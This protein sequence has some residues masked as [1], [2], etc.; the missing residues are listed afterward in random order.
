VEL[1]AFRWPQSSADSH[2]EL[3]K[4][5]FMTPNEIPGKSSTTLT[6]SVIICAYT[7]DRWDLMKEAL[8]SVV[9]QE[10]APL[11]V[12]LCI[13]HNEAL[14]KRCNEELAA[15]MASSPWPLIIL[16]NRFDTRLGGARTTAAEIATGDILAFL[17]DDAA[18]TPSWL[19]TL[20]R[21]YSNSNIVAVGGAPVARYETE[22]PRWLPFECNWIFGCSYRGLPERVGP[23]DH[24]IGA[25][26][27]VRREV[28]MSWGGFQS[29]NHDDMDLSHRAIHA[30]G[31]ASVLFDPNAIVYHFVPSQRL[32][33]TYFWRRCFFV[34]KG[35]VAAFRTMGRASN[36]NAEVKFA[37]RSLTRALVL[38]GRELLGGDAYAPVRYLAL[39]TAIGLGGAGAV[40]GRLK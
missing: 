12:L 33:W 34:N 19:A 31:A 9:R 26:M 20:T 5:A 30:H 36:L 14:Y 24:M 17:D 22:R 23:V 27:S 2:S 8:A 7:A 15:M 32:T 11:E 28:L 39:V 13:D 21:H 1:A 35:K 4:D 6:L 10:L 37:G 40:A 29:D 38:E 3:Q 25:N 18:A 16:Q